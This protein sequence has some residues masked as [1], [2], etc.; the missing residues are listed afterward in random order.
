MDRR[1]FLKILAISSIATA[2]SP[3]TALA[4]VFSDKTINA[5]KNSKY[6]GRIKPLNN[7]EISKPGK[8]LG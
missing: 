4:K 3:T 2:I 5:L 6:P 7:F 1:K 8:W